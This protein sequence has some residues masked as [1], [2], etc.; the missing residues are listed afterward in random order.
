MNQARKVS[1]TLLLVITN[2]MPA[3]I[4]ILISKTNSP[5]SDRKESSARVEAVKIYFFDKMNQCPPSKK[6][7]SWQPQPAQV[8]FQSYQCL[9][10]RSQ[11]YNSSMS[12]TNLSNRL[13]HIMHKVMLLEREVNLKKEE[14]NHWVKC[15]SDSRWTNH[16]QTRLKLLVVKLR[17]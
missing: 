16:Y 3:M 10:V 6:V 1:K 4:C 13:K 2:L 7:T 8:M 5:N 15:S 14:R 11:V 12:I 9:I 17:D